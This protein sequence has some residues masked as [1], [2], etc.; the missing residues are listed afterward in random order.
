MGAILVAAWRHVLKR[1]RADWLILSAA[2]LTI[3]L[4][5]TL[6][7]AG[8]IYSSAVSISGL[9]RTL[10]DAD[11]TKANV[12]VYVDTQPNQYPDRN[13]VVRRTLA[14][15]FSQI[16]GTI[17]SYG[18]SSSFAL[19]GQN[20]DNVT[21]LMVFGYFPNIA[22][23]A[24]LLSGSWPPNTASGTTAQAAI[25]EGTARLLHLK[26]GDTLKVQNRLQAN[27]FINVHVTGIY[28]IN[29]TN[30]P[31]W[32][33]DPLDTSGIQTGASFTTYG[34][35]VVSNAAFFGPLGEPGV[36]FFW[37]AFPDFPIID[38]SMLSSLITKVNNLQNQVN[39]NYG[40]N[41]SFSVQTD[42]GDILSTAQR[43]LLVTRTGVL[44]VTIQ[45]AILAGYALL[46]TAGLL[47]DQR[48]VEMG[49]LHSRGASAAQVGAMAL[50]EALVLTV[51]A[52]IA[53]PWLAT[54]SLR[55]LN[56]LGPLA[57]IQLPVHPHVS[58]TA[59]ALSIVAGLFCLIAL[60]APSFQAAR[61]FVQE[62][63]ARGR[64]RS[65]SVAQRAGIDLFLLAAAA[66]AYWQLRRYG[67][68]ITQSV[69]GKY[70][71]DPLL[72]A[73]PA[74]GLLAGAII[75]LRLIPLLARLVD[76]FAGRMR[77]LVPALGAWQLARRP[78]AYARSALLLMLAIAIGIFAL[79]YSTT[80]T[81]SQQDQANYQTGADVRV[82]PDIRIGTAI[83]QL[84]LN[85]AQN[86][87][88]G[89]QS[90]MPVLRDYLE[91]SNTSDDGRLIALDASRAGK[92]VE[93]RP[94][95][96]NQ[97]FPQMMNQ[98]AA[99]RPKIPTVIIPGQP[100][101]I[102]FDIAVKLDPM[103]AGVK[104]PK[105]GASLSPMIMV[106]VQDA[107][108][109]LYQLNPVF[110]NDDG[111]THRAIFPLAFRDSDGNAVTPQYPVKLAGVDITM[112]PLQGIIRT[113]QLSIASM[114][115]SS[116]LDGNDWVPG[117]V[118]SQAIKWATTQFGLNEEAT[119]KPLPS[120]PPNGV[121]VNFSCPSIRGF[122][123][124]SLELNLRAAG[125]TPPQTL[126]AIV[127]KTFLSETATHLGDTIPIDLEGSRRDVKITG[128]VSSF[129]TLQ[130]DQTNLIVDLPTLSMLKFEADGGTLD[131]SEWWMSVNSAKR[132]AV[133][134]AL[135][136]PPYSSPDVI[137][138]IEA[139]ASLRSDPV[140]L[141]IIGALSLG[142][143]A[144]ALFAAL[145]FAVSA[146][147]SSWSRLNEFALLR[148]L[149]LSPSQL[150][151]WLSLENGLLVVI[152][153]AG[154]TA[155]G[156]LLA[157][158]ILP[159]VSL[160]QAAARTVPS[161]IVLI[162]WRAVVILEGSSLLVL[163]V[164]IAVLATALRRVGLGSILRLGEE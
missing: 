98:L 35:F 72:V 15:T 126:P 139:G 62:R 49:L 93:F 54:L 136:A 56:H 55:I 131:P 38:P 28:R 13:Q 164:V 155:L 99:A 74:I 113:G 17:E 89:I 109:M 71:L 19:P 100:Q 157:W 57:S 133:T 53:G 144:A 130:P 73:A 68:P 42:L 60:A 132:E 48:R 9:R 123:Y 58:S 8:P 163:I 101:R 137:D 134:A 148:A 154:G 97:S 118:P 45:L 30:D 91:T 40:P 47:V 3:I 23:H 86:R 1:A 11:I 66:V 143:V 95:L 103:P 92:I 6:L 5:T 129:P 110:I 10:H 122:G 159:L 51:P 88:T 119:V 24:K 26:P 36:T 147:V 105:G 117:P 70:G 114:L 16:P 46:L 156:L 90:T 39:Q 107:S 37:R 161:V 18:R 85:E 152:S 112:H 138:R 82:D 43:S 108:G 79:S 44:V 87:I 104:P 94:D 65:R 78:L 150:S 61:S 33:S 2:F 4:A 153:L 77:R 50:M 80:W 140:A 115:T 63:A 162:P 14:Q 67:G 22:K 125:S 75:A 21:N 34:P 121:A 120:Q 76:T 20:P 25:P 146:A 96:S 124:S 158:L 142:Y 106:T 151:G 69:Q 52:V 7:S 127:D 102:A 141:G 128:V 32:W 59:Y 41:S 81:R 31:Y 12:E 29:S 83:P 135:A 84:D 111:Q 145:G 160:T 149:G 116:T 64:T 27:V